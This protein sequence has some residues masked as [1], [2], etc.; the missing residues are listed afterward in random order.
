MYILY[1]HINSH[2]YIYIIEL[3]GSYSKTKSGWDPGQV[4]EG[5]PHLAGPHLVSVWKSGECVECSIKI[6]ISMK[7]I[8]FSTSFNH[9]KKWNTLYSDKPLSRSYDL[10]IKLYE[11]R[12]SFHRIHFKT[13]QTQHQVPS[14]PSPNHA[15]TTL[16]IRVKDKEVHVKPA[17]VS[18]QRQST[19]MVESA[20]NQ[21][22]PQFVSQSRTWKR[23][24]NH[25]WNM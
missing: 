19:R 4:A 18:K 3:R 9:H 21:R 10:Y 14:S 8:R 24:P 23:I 5:A 1:V 22:Q 17:S 13:F 12:A 25:S 11:A 6:A 2:V 7:K 20:N 15:A 16:P